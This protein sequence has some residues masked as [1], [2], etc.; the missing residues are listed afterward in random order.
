MVLL[1]CSPLVLGLLG[2]HPAGGGPVAA[3][4]H[5]RTAAGLH[6]LTAQPDSILPLS[7]AV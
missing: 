1:S 7:P 2:L 4:G 6:V 3:E 5:S